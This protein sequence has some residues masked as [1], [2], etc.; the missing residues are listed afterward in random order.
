MSIQLIVLFVSL[1]L[2]SVIAAIFIGAVRAAKDSRAAVPSEA[3]RSRLIK[4]MLLFGVVLTVS[5]L[6]PWPHAVGSESGVDGPVATVNVTG[7]MWYWQIDRDSVPLGVPVVFHA[8]TADVTHGFGVMD[9]TGRL[10]FQTQAM[11][12]YVNKVQHVFENP[13][14]YRIV[15]MEFCGVAHHVMQNQFTVGNK[16]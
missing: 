10:L 16:E 1:V 6:L 15:C 8:H 7:G 5:S 3:V 2:M 4:G 9:S 11:P 13:G 12:G 14:T